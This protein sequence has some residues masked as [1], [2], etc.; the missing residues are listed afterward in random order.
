MQI[1]STKLNAFHLGINDLDDFGFRTYP[2]YSSTEVTIDDDKQGWNAQVFFKSGSV[3]NVTCKGY[4]V[5]IDGERFTHSDINRQVVEA[6][7]EPTS[8]TDLRENFKHLISTY[9]P[10]H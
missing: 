8:W 9:S 1:L 5:L 6:A 7:G 3:V 2:T 10:N 4:Y